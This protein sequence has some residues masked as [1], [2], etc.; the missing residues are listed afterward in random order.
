MADA[1]KDD[2]NQA[3]PKTDP[4]SNEGNEPEPAPQ[5]G[6]PKGKPDAQKAYEQAKAQRDKYKEQVAELQEMIEGLSGKDEELKS[7][8]AEIAKMKADSEAAAKKAEFARVNSA[9]LAKEGCVDI[10]VALT[11]LDENGD[12]DALKEAKPYLFAKKGSTGLPPAGAPDDSEARRKK[13]R[14]AAGLKD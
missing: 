9:R 1:S 12:V 11:L 4:E 6:E 3:E 10:E 8:Q 14:A 13:A 5:G 7:L 2:Q